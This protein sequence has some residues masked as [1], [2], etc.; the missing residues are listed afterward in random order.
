LSHPLSLRF[1]KIREDFPAIAASSDIYL[2]S[3]ATTHKPASVIKALSDFYSMQYATVHRAVY[4]QSLI[5]TDLYDEARAKISR[6]INAASPSEVIFTKGTTD[7]VN[8]IAESFSRS[9]LTPRSRI[10]VS[11]MEH[12]SNLI[13]W[14]FAAQVSGAILESIPITSEGSLSLDALRHSLSLGNVAIVAVTHCSNVLGTINPIQTIANMVH[15][16][17][18]YLLVDG[19]QAAPHLPIDVQDLRCDAYAFSAHKMCGPTGIGVLWAKEALLDILPPTR[20]GGDMI[21]TVTFSTSTWADL[22][23]KFEPGTPPIAEAIAFGAAIDYCTSLSFP[24]IHE[25]EQALASYLT[26]RLLT[27]PAIQLIGTALPRG[28]LQAFHIPGAHPLDIATLL[29][30]E[31]IAVRSGHL[32][33]QPLLRGLSLTSVIRASLSFYNTFVEIDRFVEALREVVKKL[34]G[35]SAA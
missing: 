29:D 19:A 1:Q 15:E 10:L 16:H 28:P 17:H 27:I 26:S 2:D 8:I 4:R 12:H 3:A 6:F 9:L 14:Q 11:E 33:C 23:L 18:A 30:L 25:Y 24:A 13:P 32:C 34:T 20:G 5:A 7:S 31:G 22:P 35:M 21:D